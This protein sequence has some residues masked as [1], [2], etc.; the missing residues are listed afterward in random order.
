TDTT[1]LSYRELAER[2]QACAGE[3]V[4]QRTL[5]LL[6][7]RN[8]VD[9]LIHYLAALAAGHVVLPVPEGIDTDPLIAAYRPGIVVDRHGVHA[10]DDGPH[11]LHDDLALLMSPS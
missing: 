7:A 11:V 3:L 2:V 9:A 8:N 1:R 5:V 4:G 10:R 6:E